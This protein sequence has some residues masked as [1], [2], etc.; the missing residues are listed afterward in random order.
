MGGRWRLGRQRLA[1]AALLAAQRCLGAAGAGDEV[2]PSRTLGCRLRDA[3]CC[4]A[5]W[6]RY[7]CCC[8]SNHGSA[9]RRQGEEPEVGGC[10]RGQGSRH[11]RLA[12]G[13][14]RPKDKDRRGPRSHFPAAVQVLPRPNW[15][16][17]PRVA[18]RGGAQGPPGDRVGW[19][20]R[21]S[22]APPVA[23]SGQ[24]P[25]PPIELGEARTR[26]QAA[27]DVCMRNSPAGG[28]PKACSSQF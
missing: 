10:A 7:R 1:G 19:R 23:Q 4:I 13:N 20:S 2:G 15:G 28:L 6:H 26:L 16:V 27:L 14:R 9:G 24:H 11:Q 3:R 25:Q 17:E 12:A 22:L 18:E 8:W 5:W 21:A